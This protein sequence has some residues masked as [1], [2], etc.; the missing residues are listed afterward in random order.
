MFILV[1]FKVPQLLSN[2][3]RFTLTKGIKSVPVKNK[4]Q[5]IIQKITAKSN[6]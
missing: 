5:I 4:K 1:L 3:T 2:N 6:F